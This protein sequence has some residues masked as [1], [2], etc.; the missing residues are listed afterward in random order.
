MEN[1]KEKILQTEEEILVV[2][3]KL[4]EETSLQIVSVLCYKTHE[5]L[6]FKITL[7]A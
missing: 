6:Q 4:E 2:L 7:N 3:R 5:G 1:I